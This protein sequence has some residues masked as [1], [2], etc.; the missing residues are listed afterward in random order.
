MTKVPPLIARTLGVLRQNM[1]SS[2]D[3]VREAGW[4]D[5][6]EAVADID[7][8]LAAI[9]LDRPEGWQRARVL[10]G[11]EGPVRLLSEL[12]GWEDDFVLAVSEAEPA[13]AAQ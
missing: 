2:H 8:T 13:I 3:M 11:N 5:I 10:L 12:D 9:A 7:V 4:Q 1:L 6:E